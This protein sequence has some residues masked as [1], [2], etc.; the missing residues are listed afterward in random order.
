MEQKICG[1]CRKEFSGGDEV[2]CPGCKDDIVRQKK[3]RRWYVGATAAFL[4]LSGAVLLYAEQ[5]GWEFSLDAMLGRPVAVINGEPVS[6]SEVRER[7]RIA[8]VML[9]KEY[10]EELFVGEQGSAILADLERDVLERLVGERLVAQ[11]ASRMK[12]TVGDDR[13]KQEMQRIGGEIYG[14]WENCQASLKEDGISQE[15]LMNHVRKLLLRQEVAK[16]KAPPEI[17]PAPYFVAWLDQERRTAKVTLNQT[18]TPLQASAQGGGSCCGSGGGGGAVG[19]NRAGSAG[20]CGGRGGG[21]C[22][23]KQDGKVTDN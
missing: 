6:R 17:D 10:G 12:I 11:E 20:G 15:Y 8:R 3:R 7:F 5:I 22:G 19:G 23:T 14:N 21:G 9:E 1:R 13:V 2:Y 4:V 18:I 16:A